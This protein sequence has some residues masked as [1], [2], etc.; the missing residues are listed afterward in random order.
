MRFP[1]WPIKKPAVFLLASKKP[2]VFLLVEQN[3]RFPNWLIKKPAVFSLAHQKPV[4]FWLVEQ[5]MRFPNWYFLKL[6]ILIVQRLTI[7]QNEVKFHQQFNSVISIKTAEK[8]RGFFGSFCE[9]SQPR[10]IGSI[11]SLLHLLGNLRHKFWVPTRH[12]LKKSFWFY[13][14]NGP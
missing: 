13:L 11:S 8:E 9:F 10:V 2:A 12:T 3:M 7:H 14:E 1:N 4:V 6:S 5:N